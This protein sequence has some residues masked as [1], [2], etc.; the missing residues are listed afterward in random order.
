MVKNKLLTLFVLGVFLIPGISYAQSNEA[1]I[2]QIV[3]QIKELQNQLAE[4]QKATPSK[5][6]VV[7]GTPNIQKSAT[8]SNKLVIPKE[9]CPEVIKI[10]TKSELRE[11]KK[12]GIVYRQR[13]DCK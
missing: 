8:S 13:K 12:R 4:L 7:V 11:L 9:P 10:P 5:P 6:G 2:Q 3:R 1:L